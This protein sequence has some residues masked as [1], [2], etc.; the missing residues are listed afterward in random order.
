[1][2]I[3]TVYLNINILIR[4]YSRILNLESRYVMLTYNEG[5]YKLILFYT[6]DNRCT[7]DINHDQKYTKSV[8]IAKLAC[9]L[10]KELIV[11][12]SFGKELLDHQ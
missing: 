4:Y 1:M 6:I 8:S 5:R 3:M 10:R 9:S 12:V 11:V 7:K 2:S